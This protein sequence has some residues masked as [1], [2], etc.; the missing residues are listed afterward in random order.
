MKTSE[1]RS[2]VVSAARGWLGTPYESN[3]HI[4]GA[5]VDCAWLLIE[6]FSEAGVI[7][8]FDPGKYPPDW[9]LHKSEER[10]VEFIERFAAEFDW[11]THPLLP[12]DVVVW[13]YGWTFSH[14]AIVSEWPHVIHAFGPFRMVDESDVSLGSDLTLQNDG[15]RRPMRAFS[16]WER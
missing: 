14:G 1:R 16:L 9:H 7:E 6:A 13:R 11:R 8:R 3:A 15:R 10:Y 2:S 12:G 4:K 5:G